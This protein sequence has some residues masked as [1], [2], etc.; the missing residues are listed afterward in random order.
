MMESV[1]LSW[2]K[3]VT[4]ATGIGAAVLVVWNRVL[5]AKAKLATTNADIAKSDQVTAE[6]VAGETVFKL[7]ADRLTSL[8]GELIE[9][10]SELGRVREQLREKDT[11]VH[12]LRMHIVD[13][14]HCLRQHGITP[15]E[16]RV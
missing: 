3:I 5:A 9:M 15:P 12:K 16:M 7:V 11:E 14:E 13:L 4:G 6:A 2:E 1:D 8:E 10:R